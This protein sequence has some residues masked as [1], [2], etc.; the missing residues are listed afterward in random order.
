MLNISVRCKRFLLKTGINCDMK[1]DKTESNNSQLMNCFVLCRVP[2]H[3]L[4]G[5]SLSQPSISQHMHI[6]RK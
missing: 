5:I 6:L 3:V 2:G 4:P 1:Y